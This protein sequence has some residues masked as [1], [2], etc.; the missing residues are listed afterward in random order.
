[1]KK[2]FLVLFFT[3]SG[4]VSFAQN[5]AVKYLNLNKKI[6][7]TALI[8]PEITQWITNFANLEQDANSI[9][10]KDEKA[11]FFKNHKDKF[12]YIR[13]H[14]FYGRH[15]FV[16]DSLHNMVWK[17]TEDKKEIL[18][19]LCKSARTQFRGRSYT[20]Y[21][22]EEIPVSD[23]PWKFGGLPG[24][25]LEFTSDDMVY[26]FKAVEIDKNT[27]IRP[28]IPDISSKKFVSWQEYVVGY[29]DAVDRFIAK[30]RAEKPAGVSMKEQ[31]SM[32]EIIYPQLEKGITY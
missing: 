21:Y 29:K 23:G 4:V 28:S 10:Y 16:K 30:S 3:F 2:I 6:E 20:V 31:T 24:L 15:F 32:M 8:S 11:F 1:M 13:T 25:I 12:C 14:H 17:L 27:K 22:T 18:G 5:L 19:M 26:G 9:Q 7:G